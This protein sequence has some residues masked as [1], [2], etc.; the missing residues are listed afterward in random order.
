M[1]Y[2]M[3]QIG[4]LEG[5]DGLLRCHRNEFGGR[6]RSAMTV[7]LTADIVAGQES[8]FDIKRYD[9]HRFADLGRDIEW[10]AAKV[11]A[12]VSAGYHHQNK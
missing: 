7:S 9:P 4:R 8:R 1:P 10:L 12:I 11:S 6:H 3:P 2:G 5:I